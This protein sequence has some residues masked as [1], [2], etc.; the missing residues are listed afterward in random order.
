M[1]LY[2]SKYLSIKLVN[3]GNRIVS[4]WITSP[5]SLSDFKKEMLNFVELYKRFKPCQSL[6]LQENF[7]FQPDEETLKWIE[8]DIN[9]PCVLY[10]N[11]KVAMVVGRDILAHL[12]VLNGFEKNNTSITHAHF[13]TEKDAIEWLDQTSEQEQVLNKPEI[14]FEGVDNMGNVV[15]NIKKVDGDISRTIKSFQNLVEENSF[16]K[17]NIEK[18]ALL[19]KREK[20][21]LSIYAKGLKHQDIADILFISLGTLRTHWKNIKRKLDIKSIADVINYVNAFNIRP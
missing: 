2:E 4:Y 1:N 6:W 18:Y 11:K 21:I 12:N 19:T 10:G 17:N 5:T 14:S 8:E 15:I 16:I 13:A 20:Q 7:S 9:K 3:N